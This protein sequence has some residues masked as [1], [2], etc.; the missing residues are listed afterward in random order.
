MGFVSIVILFGFFVFLFYREVH[1]DRKN[2][3]KTRQRD[4][5]HILREVERFLRDNEQ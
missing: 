5:E 2:F 3:A 1:L 4:N